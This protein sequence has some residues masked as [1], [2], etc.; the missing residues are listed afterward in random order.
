MQSNTDLVVARQAGLHLSAPQEAALLAARRALLAAL[1]KLAAARSEILANLGMQLLQ[2]TRV[3]S[4]L[5][6]V[7]AASR[8]RR[9]P[10]QQ[11]VSRPMSC[12]AKSDEQ[13]LEC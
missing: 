10:L 9:A 3:C 6:C 8:C 7:V 13:P 1:G 4:A 11:P 5:C 2:T 12:H